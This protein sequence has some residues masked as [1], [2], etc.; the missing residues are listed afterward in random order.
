MYPCNVLAG[1]RAGRGGCWVLGT[2]PFLLS[3]L[4]LGPCL[5]CFLLLSLRAFLA[6]ACLICWPSLRCSWLAP[7]CFTYSQAAASISAPLEEKPAW[8]PALPTPLRKPANLAG[9]QSPLE[10][11]PKFAG[12]CQ[13]HKLDKH[14]PGCTSIRQRPLRLQR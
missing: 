5:Q 8:K 10:N 2:S 12:M 7:C 6:Q 3:V 9:R 14:Y 1:G 4:T 13:Q 11:S